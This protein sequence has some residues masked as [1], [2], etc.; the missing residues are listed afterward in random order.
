MNVAWSKRGECDTFDLQVVCIIVLLVFI[1]GRAEHTG[2]GRGQRRLLA[3]GV[4]LELID[5]AADPQ[6]WTLADHNA[7]LL[8]LRSGRGRALG[9]G[10][11]AGRSYRK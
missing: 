6:T 7:P 8:S 4:V 3:L 1:I 10:G 11:G 2:A 5:H 9:A